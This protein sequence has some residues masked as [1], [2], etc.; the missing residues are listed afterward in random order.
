MAAA[1]N[2]AHTMKVIIFCRPSIDSILCSLAGWSFISV[3]RGS[4]LGVVTKR[5]LL[6]WLGIVAFAFTYIAAVN[7]S[8]F[9]AAIPG[10]PFSSSFTLCNGLWNPLGWFSSQCSDSLP[11]RL[12]VLAIGLV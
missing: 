5:A 9:H 4:R 11:P 7:V 1:I 2:A 8:Q 12:G 3:R 6:W 10:N